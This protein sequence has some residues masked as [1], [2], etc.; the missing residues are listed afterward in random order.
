MVSVV[1]AV[2]VC[3]GV[4]AGMGL[5]GCPVECFG[6]VVGCVLRCVCQLFDCS[7]WCGCVVELL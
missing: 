2:S 7:L 6:C 1:V 3:M 4:L 5:R